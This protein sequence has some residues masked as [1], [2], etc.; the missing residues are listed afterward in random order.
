MKKGHCKHVGILNGKVKDIR[1]DQR[2]RFGCSARSIKQANTKGRK[3]AKFSDV[4]PDLSR[5]M[6]DLLRHHS[7]PGSEMILWSITTS[8]R[9]LE[10]WL[11]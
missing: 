7:A 10:K 1:N 8:F 11:N 4:S 5:M 3:K 9:C 2:E 6:C